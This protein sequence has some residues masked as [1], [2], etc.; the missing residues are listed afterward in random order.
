MDRINYPRRYK[1]DH[2]RVRTPPFWWG[3]LFLK[4]DIIP[5]EAGGLVTRRKKKV[6]DL[7]KGGLDAGKDRQ[8]GEGYSRKA[9]TYGNDTGGAG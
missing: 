3:Y 2:M 6:T 8:P 7:G 4:A 5:I 9:K 1:K